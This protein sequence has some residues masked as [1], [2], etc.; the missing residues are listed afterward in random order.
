MG[1]WVK[2]SCRWTE[3]RVLWAGDRVLGAMGLWMGGLAG[4]RV[5]WV[6]GW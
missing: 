3:A 5:I 6:H 4:G 2:E 1:E